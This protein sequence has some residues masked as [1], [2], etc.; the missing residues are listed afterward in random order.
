MYN[1]AVSHIIRSCLEA[2][3][4]YTDFLMSYCLNPLNGVFHVVL[5]H[6]FQG[7]QVFRQATAAIRKSR[8]KIIRGN[9]KLF[10]HAENTHH[11]V[12][13]NA[14]CLAHPSYFIGKSHFESMIGIV[15]ILNH[16]RHFYR[17]RLNG[18]THR[19]I[20]LRHNI[21]CLFTVRTYYRQWRIHV[22]IYS[23]SLSQELRIRYNGKVHIPRLSGHILYYLTHCFIRTGKY[24]RSDDDNMK[25]VFLLQCLSYLFGGLINI[26]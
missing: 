14:V 7:F 15:Y 12:R 9:I 22:I 5:R 17:N 24:G 26:I 2:Q 20:Q 21:P 13:I 4:Q 18:C 1:R 23:R 25:T 6:C 11:F 19:C 16:F 10:V 3:S 8:F